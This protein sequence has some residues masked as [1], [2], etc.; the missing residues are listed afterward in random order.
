MTYLQPHNRKRG[1][2]KVFIGIVIILVLSGALHLFSPHVLPSFFTSIAQPF[3][4]LEFSVESGSLRSPQVLLIQNEELTRKLSEVDVRLTNTRALELENAELKAM[5]GRTASTSPMLLAAVLKRPPFS[6]YD[7][8]IVDVGQNFGVASGT[9]VYSPEHI[10]IGTITDV[11]SKTSKVTLLSSPGQ[12][13]EVLIGPYNEPAIAVGRGGGQY[14]A[15]IPNEAP[16]T[17][18]D[19][20]TDP[21]LDRAPFGIITAKISN[22]A[23]PFGKVLFAPNIS[24]YKLRWVLVDK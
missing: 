24:I 17:E 5:L 22:P 4:R 11:L 7:E 3:W 8:L 15:R 12:K 14:E 9:P 6:A 18:G 19:T 16:I 2:S 1:V 13:H 23:D 10:R 21:L 20:V